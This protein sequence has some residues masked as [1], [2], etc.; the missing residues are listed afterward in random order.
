MCIPGVHTFADSQETHDS[1]SSTA[2]A[3]WWQHIRRAGRACARLIRS[4]TGVNVWVFFQGA[5]WV[6]ATIRAF[7]RLLAAILWTAEGILSV[8]RLGLDMA[9]ESLQ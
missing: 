3:W 2:A 4:A 6:I 5:Q 7:L 9:T 1:W 8:A